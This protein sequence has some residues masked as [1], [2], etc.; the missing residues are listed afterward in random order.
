[1]PKLRMMNAGMAAEPGVLVFADRN[2][3]AI[4]VHLEADFYDFKG[5][6]HLE[7]GFTP[8]PEQS[9]CFATLTKPSHGL[10]GD[11]VT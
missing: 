8:V 3:V 9:R 1:M 7:A 5:Q 2:L 4:L 10:S 11:S 6:W